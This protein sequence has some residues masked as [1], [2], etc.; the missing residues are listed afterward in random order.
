MVATMLVWTFENKGDVITAESV[1][2][3]K[4]LKLAGRKG[5][6]IAPTKLVMREGALEGS[7]H[8]R[9]KRLARTI[10]F[11]IAIFGADR[12]EVEARFR[13]FTRLIQDD[14]SAPRLVATYPSGERLYT[15]IHFSGG[16]DPVYGSDDT[17][18]RG[19][20]KLQMTFV[21]PSPYWTEEDSISYPFDFNVDLTADNWAEDMVEMPLISSQTSG[22]VEIEN[23]GDVPAYPVWTLRGPMDSFEASYNGQGFTYESAIPA[24]TT[25]VINT[26][27]KTV[28]QV[29]PVLAPPADNKYGALGVAP[30]LFPI[31]PGEAVVDIVAQNTTP[32][33]LVSM[34]FNARREL[35]FG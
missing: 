29:D 24:G 25:I 17:R 2:A 22:S 10:D 23:P 33:S 4:F 14:E 13:Q 6:G 5:F 19:F 27:D 21:A 9:T 15:E 32:S 35:V 26:L 30:K 16:G 3:N 31:P 1:V 28:M 18:G 8:R 34:F 20:V 7:R 11:P 12:T